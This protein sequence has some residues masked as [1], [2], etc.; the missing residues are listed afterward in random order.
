MSYRGSWTSILQQTRSHQEVTELLRCNHQNCS[1]R[2]V[3]TESSGFL[4]T[5]VS[6]GEE[7]SIVHMTS[8]HKYRHRT[9]PVKNLNLI[10]VISSTQ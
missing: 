1:G 8:T 2:T 10:R 6:M 5:P 7:S 9:I 3:V 4:T